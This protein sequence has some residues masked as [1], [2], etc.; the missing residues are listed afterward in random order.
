MP[1]L[2]RVLKLDTGDSVEL[3]EPAAASGGAFTRIRFVFKAG[4]LRVSPHRHLEQDETFEVLSGTMGYTLRG[5]K[6]HAAA[7]STVTLPRGIIHT[8]FSAGP[9]DTVVIQTM[10]P[11]LDFDY[12]AENLFGLGTEHRGIAGLD[13]IIQGLVWLRKMK[14]PFYLGAPLWLQRSLAALVTP[15]AYRFGYRAVYKRFSG[16]EW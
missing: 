15:I 5:K 3:L 9:E 2:G 10:R 8:H 12:I 1:L 6:H 13:S 11:G 4:G 16:E 14:G 7:G